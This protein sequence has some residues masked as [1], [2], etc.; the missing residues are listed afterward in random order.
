MISIFRVTVACVAA[1]AAVA[2]QAAASEPATDLAAAFGT[3]AAAHG[4]ALSP[5]G[6]KVLYIAPAGT[7]GGAVIVAE[8]ATGKTNVVF[9]S[10]STEIKPQRCRWKSETRLVCSL[11][12]IKPSG[13]GMLSFTRVLAIDA[14]GKNVKQLGQRD[15]TD[16]VGLNQNSGNV[17]D[18]L[19][20]DPDHVLMQIYILEKETATTSGGSNIRKPLSGLSVQRV[21]IRSGGAMIV[22]SSNNNALSY[23][24]DGH[25]MVRF[26]TSGSKADETLRSQIR[27]YARP[28]NDKT[29]QTLGT[30]SLDANA[31]LEFDGFDE[32]GD[33]LF[34]LEPHNGRQALYKIAADGS[35]TKALVFEHPVVDV[36]GV[37]RIGKYSRPVAVEYTVEGTEFAFFD[38]ALLKF[39]RGLQKALPAHPEVVVLDESWDQQIKLVFAS[40][41]ADPGTYYLYKEASHELNELVARQPELKPLTLATVKSIKYPAADGTMIP[42]YLTLPPGVPAKQLL[43]IIM[44]HGG[45]SDRD[46][47]SYDW[48]VQY[49]VQLGYA[50][51]QPNYRG[52]SGYGEAWYR[53]NGFKSWATAIGDVNDGARW[54]VAQGIAN[55]DKLAIVGWSYG[56][57]A[58]LQANVLDPGLYKAAVAIAPVTDLEGLRSKAL[59]FTNYNQVDAFIGHGPHVTAGSPARNAAAF[60]APVLIFSGDRDLNVDVSQA[61]TM[62]AALASAGKAHELKIYPGLD[63]QLDDSEART[64]LLR[65]SAAFLAANVK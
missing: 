49:Y 29:W 42:A 45:P 30:A 56:G 9:S 7:G 5:L 22:E 6:T 39:S 63:H 38:P 27:Y 24:T 36:D 54:L 41:S 51:L 59:R 1:L 34:A 50:V 61:R 2:A 19:P 37:L 55:K 33:N 13:M 10:T 23:G 52:S 20:D 21:D 25:G 15:S 8:V 44:P 60:R 64:D 46:I 43:A 11:Y 57:Y 14:D 18:W 12:I 48:L 17:I 53:N 16:S 4:M 32:S 35:G 65:R 40:S 28:K 3:R 31:G 26:R 62:D 58:A 47:G